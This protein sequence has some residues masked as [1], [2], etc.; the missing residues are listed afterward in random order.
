M[1]HMSHF[2]PVILAGGSGT[3]LWPRSRRTTPKQFLNLTGNNSLLQEAFARVTPLVPPGQV[4]VVTN[5]RFVTQVREQLSSL[6]AENVLGEPEGRNTAPAMGW[7]AVVLQRRDPEAVMAILTADHIITRP[8]R[9]RQALRAADAL[10][11][12]GH[13]VTLGITPTGP[14]TGYGYIE[15]GML[16]GEWYGFP[17][18]RLLRFTEKPDEE[19]ARRFLSTGR[20]S[21]NSGMFIWR[22]DR[23]LDEI[24]RHMP[25]LHA[26]LMRIA[27]VLEADNEGAVLEAVWPT[28]PKQSID[29]GIMEHVQ[30]GV[31][32]PVDIGWN[33]VGSWAALYE[34]LTR[35]EQG[36]V[37]QGEVALLDTNGSLILSQGRL[38]AVIGLQ[39]VVVVDSKDAVL[40]CSLD[41][42]QDVRA[43][44][45]ALQAQGKEDYL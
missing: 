39:N 21:W 17:A 33:D 13:L 19:T 41:R 3:R 30:E 38:L 4:L 27:G 37:V 40:V 22:V 7:A 12:E 14:V 8:E 6:P 35:D 34:E 10:A 18:Y 16:L 32:I 29:Y 25:D 1:Q 36:N 5:R 23:I 15:R 9:F 26:G 43:I 45:E 44:V 11:R 42:A 20:F 31:V 24:A 2:Y 28:L